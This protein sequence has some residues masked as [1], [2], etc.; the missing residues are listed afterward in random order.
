MVTLDDYELQHVSSVTV[1]DSR[2]IHERLIPSAI[3]GHRKDETAG[4]RIITV[5]GEIRDDPDY[6][7]RLEEMRVRA[8]D[9]ARALDFEDGSEQ[10]NA[11]LATVEA[12]WTVERGLERVGYQVTFYE[13][14]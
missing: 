13:T 3:V 5:S 12:T 10:I 6:A 4:G 8:D 14:I 7:L 11:K 1:Q 9:T 2:V